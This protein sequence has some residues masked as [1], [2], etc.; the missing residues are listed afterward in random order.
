MMTNQQLGMSNLNQSYAKPI[1]LIASPDHT[2]RGNVIHN[3]L[4]KDLLAQ[5]VTEYKIHINSQDRNT[6]NYPSPFKMKVPFGPGLPPFAISKKFKNI[7]YV[8]LD[9]IILPRTISIDVT[10]LDT[11]DI[12]PTASQYSSLSTPSDNIMTT[13]TNHKYLIVRINELETDKNLGTSVLNDK[14]TFKIYPDMSYG[15]DNVFWKPVHN[16]RVIYQDSL[17]FNVGNLTLTIYDAIGNVL[18]LVDQVGNSIIGTNIVGEQDYNA[19]MA[20][21]DTVPSV[22]YTNNVTQVEYNLT[23]GIIEAELNTQTNY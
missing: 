12:Y 16:H 5:H 8:T 6:S 17:L 1:T 23:F 22:I 14:D 20:S 21:N 9:S 7:K 4:G 19:F 2:N 15:I 11:S 3:N 18:S 13:L 10:H